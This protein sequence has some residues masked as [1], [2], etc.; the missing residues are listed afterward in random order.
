MNKDTEEIEKLIL[1]E[2]DKAHEKD[3]LRNIGP[4]RER[5]LKD[6]LSKRQYKLR[7]GHITNHN[8]VKQN[9]E[10]DVELLIET[11]SYIPRATN[12]AE[13]AKF[14]SKF[15]KP[16]KDTRAKLAAEVEGVL[17]KLVKINSIIPKDQANFERALGIISK[18]FLY[19]IADGDGPIDPVTGKPEYSRGDVLFAKF[20]DGVT[21][22]KRL[23][24]RDIQSGITHLID[25]DRT[26]FAREVRES[27]LRALAHKILDAGPKT[28]RT[29]TNALA[30][31]VEFI[32]RN[33]LFST[34][35]PKQ[36]PKIPKS[37]IQKEIMRREVAAR[38]WGDLDNV[39]S[40]GGMK[41][42]ALNQVAKIELNSMDDL[43]TIQTEL[44]KI[45]PQPAA[46]FEG[47]SY[48]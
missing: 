5:L 40:G 7:Q 24:F 12:A 20:N 23:T 42:H 34:F 32:K 31:K 15:N 45:Q 16:D 38:G 43:Q 44:K 29:S 48:E 11:A 37:E 27:E 9:L 47:I 18:S 3:N 25:N 35:S 8:G 6:L 46:K 1:T 4:N 14:I 21:G 39:I 28:I 22:E 26:K 33:E 2:I 41:L 19:E 10:N 30:D 17:R 36:L 13:K